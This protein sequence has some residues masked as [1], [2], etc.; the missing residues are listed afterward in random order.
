MEEIFLVWIHFYVLLILARYSDS[1]K[2]NVLIRKALAEL[3]KLKEAR[4][5]LARALARDGRNQQ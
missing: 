2:S 5:Y 4:R 3:G 1:A